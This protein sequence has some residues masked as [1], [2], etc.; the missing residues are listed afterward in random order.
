MFFLF[1]EAFVISNDISHGILI[2]LALT[3]AI[4]LMRFNTIK[5]FSYG[6]TKILKKIVKKNQ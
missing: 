4:I 3:F 6:V 5:V 1:V 2:A